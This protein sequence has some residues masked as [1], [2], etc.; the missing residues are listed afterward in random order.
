MSALSRERWSQLWRSA[1]GHGD[2]GPW[3]DVLVARYAEPHRYY[4]SSRHI[5]ECLSE[6]DPV[7]HLAFHPIAVELALWFHDAIY[8]THATENEEQS[9]ALAE[10]CLADAGTGTDLRLSVRDLILVTK[11]HDA[12]KHPDAPLLVDVDL[13]ILGQPEDRFWEY[14][15]QIRQEY[16]WV[17][18]VLF[19][20]RRAEILERFLAR[21][22]IYS[23]DWFFETLE[24]QARSNLQASLQR[25]RLSG[26]EN[27]A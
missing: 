16:A 18:D 1:S 5:Q 26:H 15:S 3:F 27:S 4:H 23:T 22:R 24:K 25:L 14:E 7:R 21:G 10:Q 8:D 12:S 13:S 2:G 11:T 6:F 20:A 17:S 19:S 9:A